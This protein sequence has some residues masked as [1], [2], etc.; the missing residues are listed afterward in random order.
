MHLL[1]GNHERRI[2]AWI[3]KQTLRNP[4]DAA[5][6]SRMFSTSSVLG[7]EKRRV[8]FYPQGECVGKASVPGVLKLDHC[9]FMH[10]IYTSQNAARAHLDAFVCNLVFGHTH[11]AES[12][13]RRTIVDTYSAWNPGSLCVQQPYYAHSRQTHHT[14]GYGIQAVM[15]DGFL[16]I[17]VPIIEGR[18]YLQ[19]LASQLA[20]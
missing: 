9:A 8:S 11:R 1:E 19:P 16:H 5:Y 12:A 20:G 17:N 15:P 13:T 18:S 2:G 10:G 7:L 3:A 6:L 14:H 4:A